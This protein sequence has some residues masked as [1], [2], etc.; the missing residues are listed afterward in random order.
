V[1]SGGAPGSSESENIMEKHF[2]RKLPRGLLF[3]WQRFPRGFPT[4][5]LIK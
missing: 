5:A 4:T 2:R 1:E 3:E